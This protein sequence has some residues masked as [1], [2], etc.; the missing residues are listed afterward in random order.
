MELTIT[1]TVWIEI[2]AIINLIEENGWSIEEGVHDYIAGLDDC[3][4]YLIGSEEEEKIIE[5]VKKRLDK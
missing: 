5:E 3:D 2:E 1:T 4:Y